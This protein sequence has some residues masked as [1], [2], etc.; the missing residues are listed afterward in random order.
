MY[1]SNNKNP[2]DFKGK[3]VARRQYA[4]RKMDK[5]IKWSIEN[6]GFLKY[7]DLVEQQ[8]NFNITRKDEE[9]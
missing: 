9:I 5:Y 1:G 6:R 4:I 7:K 8:E 2:R 3:D